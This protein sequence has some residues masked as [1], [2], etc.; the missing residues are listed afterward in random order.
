MAT[1]LKTYIDWMKSFAENIP[2]IGHTENDKHFDIIITKKPD[3]FGR[4]NVDGFLANMRTVLS[5]PIMVAIAY[6]SQ[7]SDNN[8]ESVFK[9][10]VGEFVLLKKSSG[11]DI[12]SKITTIGEMEAVAD[13]IFA[14]MQEEAERLVEEG[15]V[16]EL[17]L[18]NFDE[19]LIDPVEIKNDTVGVW[20]RFPFRNM[21][22]KPFEYKP[23]NYTNPL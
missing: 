19:V 7:L 23:E 6:T 12:Y 4:I 8:S 5:S 21:H 15:N 2:E 14:W 9:E 1:R 18:V 16:N 22:E 17:K 20:V 10:Q 3:E 13:K 11:K